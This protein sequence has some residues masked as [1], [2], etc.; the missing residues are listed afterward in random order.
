[1]SNNTADIA[2][3]AAKAGGKGYVTGTATSATASSAGGALMSSGL[4]AAGAGAR[5]TTV[6]AVSAPLVVGV[7]VGYALSKVFDWLFE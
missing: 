2:L 1:M 5:L 3:S 6:V 7:P 4:G